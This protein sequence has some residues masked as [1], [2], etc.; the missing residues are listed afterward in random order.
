MNAPSGMIV[1]P[2]LLY[3]VPPAIFL[4]WKC[5]TSAP[6]TT[7]RSMTIK[8]ESVSSAVVLSLTVGVSGIGLTVMVNV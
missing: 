3:S 7:A 5:V 1:V 2:L 4:I 8:P 6:S